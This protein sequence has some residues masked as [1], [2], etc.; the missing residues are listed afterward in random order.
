MDFFQE[1]VVCALS[2]LSYSPSNHLS[3]HSEL[4]KGCPGRGGP[5]QRTLS[6]LAQGWKSREQKK[7][8]QPQ[9]PV[10]KKAIGFL[11]VNPLSNHSPY[12]PI[13][14]TQQSKLI[15]LKDPTHQTPGFRGL[16]SFKD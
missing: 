12:G 4:F 15:P 2:S 11:G 13:E 14:R 6:T 8:R 3:L 9:C 7:P 10:S 16:P 1:V 5:D